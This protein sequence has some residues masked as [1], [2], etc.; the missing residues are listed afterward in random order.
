MGLGGRIQAGEAVNRRDRS[1]LGQGRDDNQ[2][3]A[4]EKGARIIFKLIGIALLVLF[5]AGVVVMSGCAQVRVYERDGVSYHENDTSPCERGASACTVGKDIYYS[6]L[7][8]AALSHEEMHARGGMRHGPWKP[9]GSEVC[10]RIEYQ[11]STTLIAGTFLCRKA[12]GSFVT[13]SAI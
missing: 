1:D 6:E 10:A 2:K 3:L 4:A 5:I 9:V 13:R 7:D 12:D 8:P 11:G